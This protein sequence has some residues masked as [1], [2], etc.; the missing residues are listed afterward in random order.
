MAKK[1]QTYEL[2][3]LVKGLKELGLV[4]DTINQLTNV[5]TVFNNNKGL[6]LLSPSERTQ[7]HKD[8]ALIR[9]ATSQLQNSGRLNPITAR[10]LS[11]DKIPGRY[12]T[13]NRI[14]S[15]VSLQRQGMSVVGDVKQF[16]NNGSFDFSNATQ[17]ELSRVRLAQARSKNIDLRELPLALS[18]NAQTVSILFARIIE[19]I[20]KK[21]WNLQ[22][23]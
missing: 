2:D 23:A 15:R 20:R 21:L 19:F 9:Q 8:L 12:G 3:I 16:Y 22:F 18:G 14:A 4:D 6:E 7:M 10:G 11:S 5:F 13:A 1:S 17:E